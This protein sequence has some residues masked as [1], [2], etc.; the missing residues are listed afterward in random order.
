MFIPH[1]LQNFTSNLRISLA[2]DPVKFSIDRLSIT[3]GYKNTWTSTR[4][5]SRANA[6][7]PIIYVSINVF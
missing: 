3:E 4:M 6:V 1:R 2:G 5:N 7:V